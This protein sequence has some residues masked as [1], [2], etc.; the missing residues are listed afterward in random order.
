MTRENSQNSDCFA[1]RNPTD[2]RP[3]P[4]RTDGSKLDGVGQNFQRKT[5]GRETERGERGGEREA[6]Q[7]G[8][9]DSSKFQRMMIHIEKEMGERA[10]Q[11]SY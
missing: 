3:S 7:S 11:T 10:E 4:N 2:F 1:C 9:K 8:G 6:S 5:E